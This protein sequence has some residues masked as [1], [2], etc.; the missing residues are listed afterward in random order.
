MKYYPLLL[1]QHR[2]SGI[3]M[4][5]DKPLSEL[6]IPYI[7]RTLVPTQGSNVS[8]NN[9]P[10]T[11]PLDISGKVCT[12]VASKMKYIEGAIPLINDIE[13][14]IGLCQSLEPVFN[15][16]ILKINDFKNNYYKLP[17]NEKK[18]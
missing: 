10:V 15:N 8:S 18:Q 14:M 5:N 16:V 2:Q 11:L 12:E 13:R 17:L 1:S 9:L 4:F 3:P 6:E 7:S